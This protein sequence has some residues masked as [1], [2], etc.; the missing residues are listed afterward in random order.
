MSRN[1]SGLRSSPDDVPLFVAASSL[2]ALVY[3]ILSH[4][5]AGSAS[6]RGAR[7]L[8]RR[9]AQESAP[10]YDLRSGYGSSAASPPRIVS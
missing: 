4:T 3:S 8:P 6:S 5:T 2:S 10:L 1:L 7:L 9:Q